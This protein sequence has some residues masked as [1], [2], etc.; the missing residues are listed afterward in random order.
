M[1]LRPALAICC[2]SSL[3]LVPLEAAR[4]DGPS[5]AIDISALS[6]DADEFLRVSG[7]NN[8]GSSGVPI[9]GGF[10]C[11]ADG[12]A[13]Y[14][15]G[16]FQADPCDPPRLG[17]SDPGGARDGAGA[18]HLVFGTGV[19][20]GSVDTA[21]LPVMPAQR[22][23]I[24]GDQAR[25]AAGSEIW[26]D[27][28]TGDGVGDL[29]IAR[30]NYTPGAGRIGA[31]ALT[32]LVGGPEL[33]TYANALQPLDLRSP[34]QSLTITNIVGAQFQDRVGIW[35]RT[36]DVT[37]DGIADI[38]VGA[39]QAS[40]SG[41]NHHGQVYVIRG[42]MHLDANQ[43]VDLTNFPAAAGGTILAGHIARI[44]PPPGSNEFHLGATVQ[45][46]DL[47]GNGRAE[48]IAAA[49]LNRSGAAL[50]PAGGSGGHASGGSVN[51]SV[52]IAWD[53]N[54]PAGLWAVGYEIDLA[55]PPG[56]RTIIDGAAVNQSFGEEILGGLD[57]DHDRAADLFVGDLVSNVG[58][59][60]AAGRGLVI[61]D[62]ASLAGLDIDLDTPPPGLELTEFLGGGSNHI[63]ADTAMQGDFDG[64]G[65]DDL[66]FSSPHASPLGRFNAGT[67]HVF[68]G[69]N[70]L[71][72][73]TID[74]APGALPPASEI[75]ISEIYGANGR[76][77]SDEGDILCYSAA[78][79]DIDADGRDDFITNEMQGN[80]LDPSDVD[81]G[82]L[83][84]LS[85]D[86]VAVPE[87]SQALLGLAAVASLTAL[88]LRRPRCR[89]AH[90]KST[91]LDRPP[92]P[93]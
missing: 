41:Q 71:W 44:V 86:L 90:S 39:D 38:A 9:A 57:Y 73:E 56:T 61:Y 69:Q 46:A 88:R 83:I 52:Y 7:S 3:L 27:D 65:F 16:A 63:A 30:Q 25:E 45:I 55:A 17:C 77:G 19:I 85:G 74:L 78:A 91:E 93:V 89:G 50:G 59:F 51:G 34:P 36:G 58:G 87:A 35:M 24:A 13:D 67:L 6:T 5:L 72:P 1:I 60:F 82:N 23:E 31:G 80:G 84:V 62:I 68:H 21:G 76:S 47:D 53:D 12:F 79:G 18:V 42:G 22:L 29:L 32:I 64:D 54:F 4:A 11:D 75:R 49:A 37:G 14:A 92:G 8:D 40:G 66:A 28:V 81:A 43:T 2:C 48:V 33:R 20:A 15:M 10:D 26:M 70:G